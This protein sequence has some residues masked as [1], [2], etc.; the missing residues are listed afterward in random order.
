[1]I[2]SVVIAL[3]IAWIVLFTGTPLWG[4]KLKLQLTD[5]KSID[6]LWG[7]KSSTISDSNQCANV[8]RTMQK[9]RSFPVAATPAFGFLTLNYTDGTTNRFYFSHAGRFSAMEISGQGGGYAISMDEMLR[10]FRRV[11]LLPK[12]M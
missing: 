5:V 6:L 7:G 9:A 8:V 12:E 4:T 11:R 1:M 3:G 2:L 10:V